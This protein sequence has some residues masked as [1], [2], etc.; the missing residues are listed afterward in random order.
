MAVN[1][2]QGARRHIPEFSILPEVWRLAAFLSSR[3]PEI[4]PRLLRIIFELGKVLGLLGQGFAPATSAF[5]CQ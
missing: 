2:Y 5:P 4:D 3:G 1:V